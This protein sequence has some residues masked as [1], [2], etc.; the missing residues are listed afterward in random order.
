[1]VLGHPDYSRTTVCMNQDDPECAIIT[2]LTGVTQGEAA[3]PRVFTV[4]INALLDHLTQTGR[5]YPGMI[6]N[7]GSM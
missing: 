7:R 2:F 3:S 1:M 4:F 6:Y 5:T